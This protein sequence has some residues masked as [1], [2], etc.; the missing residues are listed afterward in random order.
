MFERFSKEARAAVVEAQQVARSTASRSIDSRHVLVAL[1][2]ADGPASRALHAVGVDP[3]AVA[4]SLRDDLRAG[5][6]D[7]EALTSL[8][9]D[10]GAVRER[11]DAVF[12]E[13]ALDRVGRKTPKGHIP[14]TA[15]A[16]KALE[17]ALREAIRLKDTG[18]QGGHLLLGIVRADSPAARALQAAGVDVAA[19]RSAVEQQRPAA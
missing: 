19:L 1:A 7:A 10:L 9:V 2:E 3:R 15:D 18:I 17:L 8:G 6:L 4:V 14:F 16:K 11:T 13:G 5:G 12:G